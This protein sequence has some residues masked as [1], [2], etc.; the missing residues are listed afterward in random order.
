MRTGS[1]VKGEKLFFNN[2]R[3]LSLQSRMVY[4]TSQHAYL[5]EVYKNICSLI[6]CHG[7]RG[8]KVEPPFAVFFA[9]EKSSGMSMLADSLAQLLCKTNS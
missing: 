9:P 5:H 7:F 3:I 8:L 4:K 1:Y 6:H 2:P